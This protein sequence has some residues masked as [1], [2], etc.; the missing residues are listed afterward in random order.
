MKL[1]LQIA[2]GVLLGSLAATAINALLAFAG[3]AAL[4]TTITNLQPHAATQALPVTSSSG[5]SSERPYI[6]P[7]IT[8]SPSATELDHYI[9]ND[10]ERARADHD[11]HFGPAPMTAP[12]TAPPV[13]RH[14]TPEDAAEKPA[15]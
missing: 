4:S 13:I 12:A 14:A 15:R 10:S 9:Q 1:I 8:K 5:S 3:I 2:A 6:P 11:E 7:P